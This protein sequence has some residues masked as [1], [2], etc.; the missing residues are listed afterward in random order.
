M[1][2]YNTNQMQNFLTAFISLA[3][4]LFSQSGNAQAEFTTWGNM[5][6]IRV[7][8]Q[9]MEFNTSLS[10]VNQSGNTWRTRKEGQEMDFRRE[11]A[12]KIF[13]YNI[14]DVQWTKA[15]ET[16]SKGVAQVNISFTS[17][18][19]TVIKGAF[20]TIELPE[21][22][23]S[24]TQFK[25]LHQETVNFSDFGAASSVAQFKAPAKGIIITSPVRKLEIT[26]EKPTEINIYKKESNNIQID[27]ALTSGEISANKKLEN[28][29]TI[30]ATGDIDRETVSVKIFSQQEGE[31][32]EGLG[33]NFRLQNTRTDPQVID[34]NLENLQISWSR[35]EMPWR[36]WHPNQDEDPAAQAR[37]GNIHP[38][39]KASME[40]GCRLDNKG[41]QVMLAGW[42]APEW[43]IVG[44][45]FK[46]K[47]PDGSMGNHLDLTKKEAIYS[48]I[49]SYVKYMKEEYGVEVIL[50]SFNESNLGIDVRQTAEEHNELIKELGAR[51]REEGIQTEFLLGDT[52]DA[53]GWE[54]TTIASM[55][56]ETRPYIGGVSFHSWRGWTDEN[57]IKWRD[58][59]NRVDAPLYVGEGSIDA[60]AWRYPLIFEEPTYALDEI[61]VYIKMMNLAQPAS[62]LQWQLTADYSVLSGGGIFG[63]NK[64]ELY[65]TQ[66]FFNLQQ[67][68]STPVGLKAIPV[69]SESKDLTIAALGDKETGQYAVHIVNKGASRTM[70]LSGLPGNINT[71]Q[72]YIT[73]KA[74]SFKKGQTVN[75]K[76][77]TAAFEI[78][79]A[80]YIS[81]LPL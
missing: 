21:E 4:L 5:T 39:V 41:I 36:E 44:A 64:D 29:F 66:R 11:G 81:L 51:F 27:L 72:L 16:K 54:F 9:L 32:W 3:F 1:F 79:G 25:L 7:D 61:E 55:D 73:N 57:L 59:S 52:A 50:F 18:R 48:S 31:K 26:F 74:N 78:E 63:N 56:P 46:G 45:P 60:G 12:K 68:G 49:V 10:I 33:G 40:L 35:I 2:K 47:H 80:S 37:K 13:E 20:F 23:G 67:L 70:K 65:P 6:G 69:K 22:F 8:N 34:Y 17:P 15:M 28:T 43:A 76:N 14:R 75:F 42:Y 19:D 53:N 77:G 71:L 62:I 38:K 24:N 30:K 58:I